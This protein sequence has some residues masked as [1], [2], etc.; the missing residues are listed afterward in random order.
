MTGQSTLL[1]RPH[2]DGSDLYVLERPEEPGGEATLRLRVPHG[3]GVD[4]VLLRTLRD[5]E[6]HVVAAEVDEQGDGETWWRATFRPTAT[7]TRYRWLLTG[8]E[9]RYSWLTGAG[10]AERDVTDGDDFLLSL[11]PAGPAWHPGSVVYEI[12]PDRFASSGIAGDPPEWAVPRGWDERPN[13]RHKTTGREWYGGDLGGIEQHLDHVELLGANVLYLTPFFPAGSTHRYDATTFDRVDPLLGGD[14]ALRSL[15]GAAHDRGLR[16]LGDLTLNHVGKGHEWFRAA[17]AD[18][19]SPERGFFYFDD[20]LPAG[21]ACWLGVP[22]LPKLDWASAELRRR[23]VDGVA[24]RWLR[25]GL[26]GWRIDV[27]NMVA[28]YGDYDANREVARLVRSAL[29]AERADALLVAEHGHDFRRDLRGRGWHG[30][31]NYA[32]FLRPVWSWLRRADLPEELRRQFWA[33]PVELAEHDGPAAV[34]TMDS[35]RR[36]VPW[37]A[38]LHSWTL[39]D[40]HDVA[41]FRTVAGSRARQ[42]VGIGLQMTSPGVPLVFAGDEIGLDGEWGEDARRTMPWDRPETWDDAL[43]AEYRRLVAL[44]RSSDALARGGIRYVHV[45]DD[46]FAYLRETASERLLCLAARAPHDPIAVP[47]D[48]LETLYGDDAAG[49]VLPSDGPAFHIWRITNG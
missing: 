44:R 30:T 15:L 4:G 17:Q 32:G 12:F 25:E 26:D 45:S 35:F 41:R 29:E 34:A 14:E 7:V 19:A 21:Y 10:V 3:A 20:S 2:H 5:G 47:F 31:M 37:P 23:L 22:S 38:L 1:A 49:G 42:L 8:H 24:R 36:G 46:A 48:G 28:R 39:L 16:V 43:F 18:P 11:D 13:G 27:A 6:P 40:S 9:R 33:L